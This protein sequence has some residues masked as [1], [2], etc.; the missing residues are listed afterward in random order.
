[1]Y[2]VFSILQACCISMMHGIWFFPAVNAILFYD[3]DSQLCTSIVILVFFICYLEILLCH[4][5][6]TPSIPNDINDNN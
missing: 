5:Y 2:K 1:M 3:L 6:P 4:V